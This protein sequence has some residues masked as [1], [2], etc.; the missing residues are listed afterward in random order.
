MMAVQPHVVIGLGESGCS[1]ARRLAAEDIPFSVG[2]DHPAASAMH[3][4]AQ[5]PNPPSI[6]PISELT[7]NPGSKW[8]VSPGVPL[9][10]PK[11]REAPKNGVTLTN[12][13]ALFADRAKA[14]LVGI[15]GSNGKTTVTS[16]VE[17]LAKRQMPSVRVGGNI[18]TPCLD[19]LDDTTDCYVLELSSYQLELAQA[20]PLEVGALLNLSPDHLDRYAS[21]DDYYAVKSSIFTGARFGVVGE[22]C[23]SYAQ[24]G[25]CES[26]SVFAETVSAACP[27]FG[28]L[29]QNGQVHLAQGSMPLLDVQ[30]LGIEGLSNWLNVLAALAIGECLGLDMQRMT[31]DLPSFKGLPHR[32]QRI[33]RDD[34]CRWINDS[35]ATNVGA[36]VAAIRSYSVLGSLILLLGGQ[37][38][39]ADFSE[40]NTVLLEHKTLKA[41]FAYGE[42]AEE[43]QQA[44][45]AGL[46]VM[47]F[48][49]FEDM[50][51]RAIKLANA[52]DV[53]LLSPACASFDQFSGYEARGN[54]FTAMLERVVS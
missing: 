11:L 14:P 19:L 30:K 29:E 23:L 42:A 8:I 50:V 27:G 1:V 3:E 10:L 13:V 24:K 41:V 28:L 22:A 45:D 7:M 43:L 21:V 36:A 48:E 17:H 15:T 46:K 53:V 51:E 44:L 37:S 34:G 49:S 38:K 12:D 25:A 18:G 47:C 32:C 26:L 16:I 35:K 39:S 2:E 33:Q 31:A 6:V 5:L 20:L 52:G 9:S 54:C 4:M 40:L